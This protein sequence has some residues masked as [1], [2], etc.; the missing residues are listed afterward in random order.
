[1]RTL[2]SEPGSGNLPA[3]ALFDLVELQQLA[4]RYW[5]RA[6][7]VTK[8]LVGDL[9]TADATLVLGSLSLSG[10][11]AIE[12]FFHERDVAQ[13]SSGRITRHAACNFLAEYAAEGGVRVTS[14]VLVFTG[15]GVPPLPVSPPSG[16]ADFEDLCVRCGP[17][18]WKFLRRVA[19]SVFLGSDAPSF[20][21]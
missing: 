11:P 20:A 13:A 2:Q 4:A 8:Y 5:A 9:F 18:K 15:S 7:G 3:L 19:R 16:I 17:G 1:M 12:D 10:L 6:D 14:T 21:R